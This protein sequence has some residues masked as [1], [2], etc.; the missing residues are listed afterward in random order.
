M[1][2]AKQARDNVN[3]EAVG[4]QLPKQRLVI[5]RHAGTDHLALQIIKRIF[6]QPVKDRTVPPS[7][8]GGRHADF[9]HAR[10][11]VIIMIVKAA[12]DDVL[13]IGNADCYSVIGKPAL[14]ATVYPLFNEAPNLIGATI[15][16]VHHVTIAP[17]S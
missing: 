3:V 15:D 7:L 6:Q 1:V 5:G 9:D 8:V 12:D 13:I 11:R 10:V 14:R 4:F 16:K 17:V 2:A